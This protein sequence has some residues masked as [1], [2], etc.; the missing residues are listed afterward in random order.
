MLGKGSTFFSH[1]KGFSPIFRLV[2]IKKGYLEH[3]FYKMFRLFINFGL[4]CAR[5]AG[6]YRETTGKS[7]NKIL[8]TM[9]IYYGILTAIA[10]ALLLILSYFAGWV[11]YNFVQGLGIL[12]IIAGIG[13]HLYFNYKKPKYEE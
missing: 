10:G 4:I 9:K 6:I 3:F 5:K 1:S 13:L 11:D 2:R 7:T 12:L 8:K